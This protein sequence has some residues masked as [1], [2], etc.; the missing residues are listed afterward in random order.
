MT[1][2]RRP[3]PEVIAAVQASCAAVAHRPVHLA[4]AF[5]AHLFDMAPQLRPMFP[6]DLT[7][8]MQKMS[9]TLLGAVAR[10]GAGDTDQLELALQQLGATHHTRYGV[11]PDH[12]LYIGHALTRAVRDV[13]GPAF[14]GSLSSSWIAVYQ[15]IAGHMTAGAHAGE[16]EGAAPGLPAQRTPDQP[17]VALP[18]PREPASRHEMVTEWTSTG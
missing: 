8:Q 15:W 5:Y 3:G 6:A 11:Q 7:G 9:D 12:Y 4:E 16:S 1:A 17:V 18:R 10:L 13:S 14:S 2:V